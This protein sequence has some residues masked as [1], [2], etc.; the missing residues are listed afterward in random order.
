MTAVNTSAEPLFEQD[1]SICDTFPPSVQ[2]VSL[3]GVPAQLGR[4]LPSAGAIFGPLGAATTRGY[5]GDAERPRK[6]RNAIV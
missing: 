6:D 4:K 5:R 2:L 1:I 3:Q